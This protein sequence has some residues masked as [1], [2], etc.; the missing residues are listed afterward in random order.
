MPEPTILEKNLSLVSAVAEGD[1]EKVAVSLQSGA[2]IHYE[3]DL[4]LRSA[5]YLGYKD[6]VK[7]LLESGANVHADTEAA[8][9]IAIKARDQDMINQLVDKGATVQVILDRRKAD[10]DAES[11]RLIDSIKNREAKLAAEKNIATLR[12]KSRKSGI[13]LKPS[14]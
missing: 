1:A 5:A 8:L 11:L 4:A 13:N 12:E 6:M 9:F 3:D 2:N 14:P 7:L 10:L